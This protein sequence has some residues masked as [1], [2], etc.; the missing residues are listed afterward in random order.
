MDI[1][2]KQ[3]D[4]YMS[5]RTREKSKIKNTNLDILTPRQYFNPGDYTELP[6]EWC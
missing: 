4:R 1:M 6:R 3:M 2:S 5:K